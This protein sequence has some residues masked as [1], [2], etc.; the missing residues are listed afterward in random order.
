MSLAESREGAFASQFFC[1]FPQL[2]DVALHD[3]KLDFEFAQSLGS[4]NAFSRAISEKLRAAEVLWDTN[5]HDGAV[6]AFSSALAQTQSIQRQHPADTETQRWARATEATLYR[7][8]GS[9]LLADGRLSEAAQCFEQCAHERRCQLQR[10]ILLT[11]QRRYDDA[12]RGLRAMD[13]PDGGSDARFWHAKALVLTRLGDIQAAMAVIERIDAGSRSAA[14]CLAGVV[15]SLAG[16]GP[17]AESLRLCADFMGG[18][19]SEAHHRSLS[20]GM[21]HWRPNADLCAAS[22][23]WSAGDSANAFLRVDAALKTRHN[24]LPSLIAKA[25]WLAD[26]RNESQTA[27]A[28]TL[29]R[30]YRQRPRPLAVSALLGMLAQRQ[31][32]TPEALAHFEELWRVPN[33]HDNLLAEPLADMDVRYSFAF[34]LHQKAATDIAA[35]QYAGANGA[36]TRASALLL[37]NTADFAR[38]LLVRQC[39]CAWKLRHPKVALRLCEKAAQMQPQSDPAAQGLKWAKAVR[40]AFPSC[41]HCLSSV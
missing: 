27:A 9:L 13:P 32:R 25:L 11:T 28:I 6:T 40:R 37:G 22:S 17:A 29:L 4:E 15:Y 31:G 26:A 33:G 36:V 5:N 8:M 3:A 18:S 23:Y 7:N 34:A 21:A 19:E 20:G 35:R 14:A 38:E 2:L 16:E 12:A 39:E 24:H 30:N 41:A 1:D 10:I